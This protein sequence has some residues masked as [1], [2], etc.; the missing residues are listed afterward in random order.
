MGMTGKFLVLWKLEPGRL[1]AEVARAVARMPDHGAR[2]EHEG[3]LL[4]RYHVVGSHG[5]AWIY[6]AGSHEELD[7]LLALSPVYN[8]A[9]YEV[10]VLA[11]MSGPPTVV[12]PEAP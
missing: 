8:F 12:A 10:L 5:G 3:K 6:E 1:S 9:S 2:L 11:E 7:S 4:A